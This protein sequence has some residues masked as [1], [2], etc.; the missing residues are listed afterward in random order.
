MLT[1]EQAAELYRCMHR[2][3]D[4]AV[5]AK[6][7]AEILPAPPEMVGLMEDALY[8]GYL[9]WATNAK[10]AIG[11][12]GATDVGANHVEGTQREVPVDL[13]TGTGE[14]G[15]TELYGE[16]LAWKKDRVG[17]PLA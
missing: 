6:T 4:R 7:V 15:S 3:F 16:F 14:G 2:S 10:I 11:P 1:R 12:K 5:S 17:H 8:R 13:R 9:E